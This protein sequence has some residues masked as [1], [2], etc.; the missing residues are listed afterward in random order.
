MNN[1]YNLTTTEVS[2]AMIV[3]NIIFSLILQL[4]IVWTYK[5][6]HK[7]LSYSPSFIFTLVIVGVLGTVLMMVVQNNL[8][9]AF[10]LLGAFSLIRFRTILKETRDIAFV[11]F[12][13]VI[14]VSVGTNHYSLALIA[15]ISIVLIVLLLYRFNVGS[16]SGGL[17]YILTF[18][19]KNDLDIG[20]IKEVLGRMS[21]SF[22]LMQVRSYGLDTDSYVFSLELKDSI[23]SVFVI[24]TLKENQSIADVEVITGEHTIEY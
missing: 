22:E 23:D 2:A 9:G 12:V 16:M 3:I 6:T 5:K 10:A 1:F 13:L 18:T 14:G 20:N 21:K 19:A 8:V 4:I 24:K 17:A 15:T 7:G 11:F